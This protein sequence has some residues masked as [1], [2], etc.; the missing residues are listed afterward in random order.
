MTEPEIEALLQQKIGLDPKIL[1]S[2]SLHRA[3]QQRMEDSG[4]SDIHHYLTILKSSPSE[5]NTLIE[6]IIVPET[7]FFRDRHPFDYLQQY[8]KFEW[9]PQHPTDTLRILSIPCSTGEEPYSIA[10]TLLNGG[11]SAKRFHIDAVDI[12]QKNIDL[13]QQ[14]IY[15]KNS[16]RG[17]DFSFRD[18]YFTSTSDGYQLKDSVKK[19]VHFFQGNILNPSFYG[20]RTSYHVIFCRNLMIYFDPSARQK[21]IDVLNKLLLE[22][23]LL[24]LG[25]SETRQAFSQNYIPIS[26]PRTFGFRKLP[27]S[28]KSTTNPQLSPP[29]PKPVSLT[30]S[31]QQLPKVF[32]TPSLPQKTHPLPTQEETLLEV[33]HRYANSGQLKEA[34]KLCE[35]YL[36][37]NRTSA[38]AYVLLGQLYQ[39]TGEETQAEQCF[40]KAIYLAPNSYKALVHLALLKEHQGHSKTA[41]LLRQR[42]QRLKDQHKDE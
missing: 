7:W 33:A 9:L 32:K 23:G 18:R 40:Q 28:P 35:T 30:Q 13:A 36:S 10:M 1:G 6:K 21:T 2:R 11:I 24:F 38:D 12:S 27:P 37:E 41:S 8:V 34:I 17:E 26:Y 42:I 16:F 4:V 22:N 25:H 20:N 15:R 5:W 3:I 29:K 19:T 39:A 31:T 14:G